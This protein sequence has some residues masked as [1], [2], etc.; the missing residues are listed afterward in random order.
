MLRMKK[1]WAG[2][3][4]STVLAMASMSAYAVDTK[5]SALPSA[6]LTDGDEGYT[7][8]GGTSSKFTMA[9]L[10]TLIIGKG[11][12]ALDITALRAIAT[13]NI[14]TYANHGGLLG[15]DG[16]GITLARVNG[17]TDKALV[18]SW[19]LGVV[20][21]VQFPPFPM[22][23][24]LDETADVTIHLI[25]DMSAANDTPT[26]DVQVFNSVGDSEMGGATAALSDTTAELTVTI[27]N[28]DI[29]GN[30]LGYFNISLV[31]GAHGSDIMRLRAAWVEYTRKAPS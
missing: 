25:M 16:A 4:L 20:T 12:Y 13:N 8:D 23:M 30:P 26:V 3:L 22:P 31:P 14:D 24:D 28:A 11:F 7:N 1:F 9:E 6:A 2:L 18:V 17:A 5:L 29:S 27:G 15:S 21:E 19:P 10:R